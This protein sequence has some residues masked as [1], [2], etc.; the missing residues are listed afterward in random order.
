MA[1][2]TKQL[3]WPLAPMSSLSAMELYHGV[4]NLSW[5]L[6]V[7]RSTNRSYT[8]HIDSWYN[9]FNVAVL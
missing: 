6:Y 3:R 2:I 9:D 8:Y 5:A 4:Q 7:P 1:D